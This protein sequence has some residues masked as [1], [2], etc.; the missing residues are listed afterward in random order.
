MVKVIAINDEIKKP[1]C[2]FGVVDNQQGHEIEREM[3]PWLTEHY[4]VIEVL[5]DG[6]QFELPALLE[7]KRT[8]LCYEKPV[9]YIHSRGAFNVWRTTLPTRRMWQEEFGNQWQKYQ[10]LVDDKRPTIA[11]PFADCAGEHRYNGFIANKAAWEMAELNPSDDRMVYERIWAG[12]EVR[13]IGTLIQSEV[14]N[15]KKIRKYLYRN[16]E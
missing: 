13:L 3:L 12:K 15:I 2:V 16:F 5:H 7:A 8:S 11:C 1:L 10:Q 6:K 4:N 14:N 9:L